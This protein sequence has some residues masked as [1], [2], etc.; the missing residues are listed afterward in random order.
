MKEE[1]FDPEL[2]ARV[3][4]ALDATLSAPPSAAVATAIAAA[5][6]TRARTV[7]IRRRARFSLSFAIPLAACLAFVATTL[8]RSPDT[9]TAYD[10]LYSL[11]AIVEVSPDDYDDYY[12]DEDDEGFVYTEYQHTAPPRP[13]SP[14]A[15]FSESLVAMQDY[16][17]FAIEM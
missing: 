11:L 2:L 15:V 13:L 4:P 9:A 17:S 5:A 3:T 16:P 10:P 1:N 7:R 14:F 8:W 6:H 12:D